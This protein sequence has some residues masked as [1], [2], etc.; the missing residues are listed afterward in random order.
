MRLPWEVWPIQADGVQMA[1]ARCSTTESALRQF[2]HL[3]KL[4]GWRLVSF[5]VATPDSR[6]SGGAFRWS[7]SVALKRQ[8]RATPELR[9][10]D[11][12]EATSVA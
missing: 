2:D 9:A 1:R 4:A 3:Q 8:R 6:A 7:V 10:A 11:L 12:E 5:K